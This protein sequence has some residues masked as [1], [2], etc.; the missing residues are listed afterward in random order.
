[1]YY[2]TIHLMLHLLSSEHLDDMH[3]LLIP[4]GALLQMID[5]AVW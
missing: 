5:I 1:M 3:M 2:Y 4:R